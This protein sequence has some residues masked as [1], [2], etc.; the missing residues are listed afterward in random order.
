MSNL[1]E[2]QVGPHP[3]VYVYIYILWDLNLHIYIRSQPLYIH[4]YE[5]LIFTYLW[6]LNL[7][8]FTHKTHTHIHKTFK[9]V[10][11]ERGLIDW[12]FP[13]MSWRFAHR[14]LCV[15]VCVHVGGA[16]SVC[17]HI[18]IYVYAATDY[19]WGD[20]YIAHIGLVSSLRG[21]ADKCT[22]IQQLV[23]QRAF[24]IRWRMLTYAGI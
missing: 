9:S 8:R 12:D 14:E 6:D 19:I 24:S 15:C 10:F 13:V 17:G 3:R 18:L 5:I 1:F 23:S 2:P 21:Y 11:E 22:C 4:I 20:A 7:L 16:L